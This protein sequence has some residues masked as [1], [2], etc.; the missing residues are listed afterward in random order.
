MGNQNTSWYFVMT[1]YIAIFK[2]QSLLLTAGLGYLF[3][4]L[5][6]TRSSHQMFNKKTILKNF[7]IFTE[8]TCV[9]VFFNKV[10]GLAT[11][12]KRLQHTCFSVNIAKFLRTVIS[13]NICERLLLI[14]CTTLYCSIK[15]YCPWL[16]L[17]VQF[18]SD[19]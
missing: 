18:A 15:K 19:Q 8:N 17:Q 9:W 6:G 2:L 12:I 7:A 16:S 10:A 1:G 14:H 13:N 4:N 11:L 3:E 5:Y